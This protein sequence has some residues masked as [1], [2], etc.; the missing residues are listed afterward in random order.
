VIGGWAYWHWGRQHKW[1]FVAVG[2]AACAAPVA[3]Y[4]LVPSA[5]ERVNL[6]VQD[7]LQYSWNGVTDVGS[8]RLRITFLRIAADLFM[9]HPFTGVGDTAHSAPAAL[10]AFA[11]AAPEAVHH[12]FRSAFHNQ[13]VTSAV[14]SGIWGLVAGAGLLLVP[15]LVCMRRLRSTNEVDRVNAAVGLAYFTVIF[16]SSLS[17]EVVDLKY[18]SSLYAAMTALLC[19]AALAP[20]RGTA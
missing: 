12:A 9:Q 18:L 2:G 4:L 7:L 11:Y 17:T 20:P 13:I 3:V 14:R 8:V 10:T 1:A 15:A 6:A 16:F 19:G 5:Y